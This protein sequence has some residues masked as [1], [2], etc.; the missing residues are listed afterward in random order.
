MSNDVL[1]RITELVQPSLRQCGVELFD[2]Q[3]DARGGAPVLRLLIEKNGGVSLEDCERVSKAVSAVL[4]AYDPIAVAYQLE[5]SSPGADRPLR[6]ADDWRRH[7]GSRVNVRY[8][9]GES[10]TVVEGRLLAFDDEGVEVE[11]RERRALV[12]VRIPA[13]DVLAARLAVDI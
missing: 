10:D 3:W 1:E 2:A 8:R 4:D 9:N 12:P 6:D 5:V 13:S 7:V 11:A